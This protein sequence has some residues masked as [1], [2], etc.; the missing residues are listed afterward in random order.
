MPTGYT[1]NIVDGEETF[2]EY[3]WRCTRAFGAMMH[4]RDDSLGAKFTVP[5]N[6]DKGNPHKDY[7]DKCAQELIEFVELPRETQIENI[8]THL[9]NAITRDEQYLAKE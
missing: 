8:R 5:D 1:A 3:V 9:K 2:E 6:A 4:M 7:L